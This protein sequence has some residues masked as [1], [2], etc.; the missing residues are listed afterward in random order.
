MSKIIDN[1]VL[2]CIIFDMIMDLTENN[3]FYEREYWVR[4]L[5]EKDGGTCSSWY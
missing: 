4:F 3:S 1:N 2:G 5:D